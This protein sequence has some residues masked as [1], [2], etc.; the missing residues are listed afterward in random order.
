ME[1]SLK[2]TK[3][4]VHLLS[5]I[6]LLLLVEKRVGGGTC[7]DIHQYVKTNKQFYLK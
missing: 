5:D 4:K 1:T 3:V 2:K 6:Y 7:S